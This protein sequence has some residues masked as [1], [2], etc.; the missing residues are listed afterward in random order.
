MIN[1][2][3]VSQRRSD[4]R[5]LH[6]TSYSSEWHYSGVVEW[7]TSACVKVWVPNFT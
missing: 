2:W 1:H 7:F 5:V 6:F 3:R 4:V